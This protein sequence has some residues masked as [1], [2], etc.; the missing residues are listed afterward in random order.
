MALGNSRASRVFTSHHCTFTGRIVLPV[1]PD[2]AFPLFSPVGETYWVP[3]WAPEFLFP[4]A[5][6]WS[7]GQIFRT[8][9]ERGDAVWIVARLDPARHRVE[10]YR[11]EPDRYVA[12]IQV[13]CRALPG[14]ESEA[15]ISYSYFGLSDAGN[16]EIEGMTQEAFDAKMA[17]WKEWIEAGES[18]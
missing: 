13:E 3:G 14:E 18:E 1:A 16:A 2:E 15:S 10:Y 6:S 12:C 9:E 11:V 4:S 5:R 8:R 7:E 17:R